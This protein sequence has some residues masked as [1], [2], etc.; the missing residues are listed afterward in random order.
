MTQTFLEPY[1]L[2]SSG[3]HTI[4][5][6]PCCTTTCLGD[7]KDEVRFIKGSHCLVTNLR[8]LSSGFDRILIFL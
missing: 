4:H 8:Y 3:V 5:V 7:V 2:L 6:T 1:L